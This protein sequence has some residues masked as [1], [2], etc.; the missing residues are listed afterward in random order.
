MDPAAAT[1]VVDEKSSATNSVPETIDTKTPQLENRPSPE[2]GTSRPGTANIENTHPVSPT[3]DR[4]ESV[5]EDEGEDDQIQTAV[6]VEQLPDPGDACAICLDTIDDDDDVRGLDCGH[7]FH[8]SCV[9]PWLTSRRACCPLCKADYYVPKP[10][11]EGSDQPDDGRRRGAPP[12]GMPAPPQFAFYGVGRGGSFNPAGRRPTLVFPGRLMNLVYPEAARP[13]GRS[14]RHVF[15]GSVRRA[16]PSPSEENRRPQQQDG[17]N[18]QGQP[19]QPLPQQETPSPGT[20]RQ[21]FSGW[22]NVLPPSR[23]RLEREARGRAHETYDENGRLRPPPN[24]SA[25]DHATPVTPAQ[26]EE[27][28]VR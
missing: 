21:R 19:D 26:L 3:I 24:A 1:P 14:G 5:G 7:A 13:A 11:A 6:P 23:M 12:D 15:P 20:W 17:D 27:G 22:R 18:A 16:Q 9:D 10:R 25:E 2:N 28:V 8:A 4:K